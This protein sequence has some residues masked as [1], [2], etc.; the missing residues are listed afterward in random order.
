MNDTVTLN[1]KLIEE[2]LL[3]SHR[4]LT[5]QRRFRIMGMFLKGGFVAAMVGL[6]FLAGS[7]DVA[8]EGDRTKPHVASI[9]IYGPIMSG[10]TADSDRIIPALHKA[11]ETTNAKVVALKINSPGGSP[12]HAGRL[13]NEI[14]MLKSEHPEKKVVAVIED[15]GASAAYYVA[16]AT[17]TIYVDQA[18]M[19]GS[20]GVISEGFG[21]SDIMNKV[22]I[23]RRVITSGE[24]KALLDPFAPVSPEI[25]SYWKQ[26]LGE[27]HQQ[28]IKA[29]TDGRGDR[30][31]AEQ[32]GIF[33]GLI[34][35]GAKSIE[36]GLTDKL[37][38]MTTVSKES[39]GGMNI[40]DYTPAPDFF[41]HLATSTR[42]SLQTVALELQTPVLR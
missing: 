20:I 3:S 28:F 13:Y 17:D 18:S 30:L 42:A 25:K 6:A 22:G 19:V 16:A 12:V 7:N 9:E 26:M 15:L 39:V 11:F 40:V 23:E 21:F 1:R 2:L 24:N 31:K 5:R 38:S 36:M 33:S 37:G 34:W 32:S 4:E 35:T 8:R 10:Q 27:V 41:K 14:R 29:V